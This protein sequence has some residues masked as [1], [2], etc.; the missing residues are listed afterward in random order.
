MGH[1]IFNLQLVV[2]QSV[3]CRK[4]EKKG[5]ILCF[6]PLQFQRLRTIPPPPPPPL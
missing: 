1:V 2:G 6:Y 3:L 4:E 5:W